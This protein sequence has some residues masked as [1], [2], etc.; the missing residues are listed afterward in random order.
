[1][2]G[3]RGV[4]DEK[5]IQGIGRVRDVAFAPDEFIYVL[6]EDTGLLI[7][8][9]PVKKNNSSITNTAFKK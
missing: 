6:T 1:M 3:N 5:L 8:I 9:L 7:R 2:D 4:S